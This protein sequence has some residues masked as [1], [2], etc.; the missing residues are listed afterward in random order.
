MVRFWWLSWGGWII[1]LVKEVCIIRTLIIDNYLIEAPI[2]DILQRLR[3]SIKTDKLKDIIQKT[4]YIMVTCPHH[5]DGRESH[6]DCGIYIGEDSKK[7]YGFV[8]CFACNWAVNFVTFVQDCFESSE[9][10]AK[11]WLIDNYGRLI[12]ST[13]SIGD[14]IKIDKKTN[15]KVI[16]SSQLDTFATWCPYLSKRGISRATC[17]RF[18]V[19]YDAEHRQV[20]FPCYDITGR[21]IMLVRRSIDNKIF[22]MDKG[23]EKPVYGL[24]KVVEANIRTV[25]ITEGPFDCLSANEYGFPAIATLGTPSIEQI[26]EINK[27]CITTIYTMFDNDSAGK[28]FTE[29]LKTRL[30]KRILVVEVRIPQGKKD[31]N[32]L[33]KEEFINAIENAKKF[34]TIKLKFTK[35]VV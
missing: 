18:N 6:P 23:V 10:F 3:V 7:T 14:T 25:L 11:K 8:H 31:I 21:L 32:D 28:K 20:V 35:K 29:F 9:A 19:K 27:S 33:T 4:D 15:I 24:D 5:K 12:N 17:N 13:T 26:N 1:I 30:D 34:D 16:D 2:I 22:Y